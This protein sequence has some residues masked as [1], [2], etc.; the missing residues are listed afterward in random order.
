M[1]SP[2]TETTTYQKSFCWDHNIWYE[3]VLGDYHIYNCPIKSFSVYT[4]PLKKFLL[5]LWIF[6]VVFILGR[7]V[8]GFLLFARKSVLALK[9]SSVGD[10]I[11]TRW[12]MDVVSAVILDSSCRM[13]CHKPVKRRKMKRL[14]KGPAMTGRSVMHWRKM[15]VAGKEL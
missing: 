10:C 7:L 11:N 1:K 14:R 9:A 15:I 12:N 2:I 13:L 8:C 3:Y 4:N 6:L 5:G